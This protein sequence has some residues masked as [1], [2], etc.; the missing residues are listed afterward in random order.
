MLDKHTRAQFG[1]TL[2]Y[3]SQLQGKTQQELAESMEVHVSAV[4]RVWRG[5]YKKPTHYARMADVLGVDLFE[6]EEEASAS[7][8]NQGGFTMTQVRHL[9]SRQ[10]RADGEP[11]RTPISISIASLKGGVGK[12]TTTIN[13]AAC[14]AERGYEVVVV[15]LDGQANA[16]DWIAPERDLGTPGSGE[17]STTA[18]SVPKGSL[19]FWEERLTGRTPSLR[20]GRFGEARLRFDGPDRDDLT[21]V[22]TEDGNLLVLDT[23]M[24]FDSNAMYRQKA[25][26]ELRDVTEEDEAEVEASEYDLA[27][28]KLDGNIGCMVNGAGLAMATMDIIKLNGA[29]PANFLDVGGGATTEKVTAAFKII[30]KDPAVEGILVNI[31]GGI[32][33]CDV[34]ANGIVQ[35]AKDVN[36]SVPLV[37]RLEGTNVEEGKAILDNSGLAIVSADDL[38]DAAKKIV[39]E[40]KQAA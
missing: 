31:F 24:S 32:M 4:S 12:T 33:K 3:Q 20:E 34:I 25:V 14:L 10:A 36:L 13:L 8:T 18:F 22:E 27:Y 19:P 37:V 9:Q 5:L 23:K 7:T 26:E 29:F 11:G 40:V 30:L 15:D 39:A 17:V 2:K 38:G 21:L 16:T 35:A 28:I 1:R 6:S